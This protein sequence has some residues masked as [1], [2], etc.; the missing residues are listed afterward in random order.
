MRIKLS[1]YFANEPL[2]R[3]TPGRR[4]VWKGH[5]FVAN[6]PDAREC[7]IWAVLENPAEEEV[8]SVASGRI[9]LVTMEPQRK[10]DYQ[11]G[12]LAQ[13]DLVISCRRD[14]PHPNVRNDCQ[15]QPWHIG[16]HKGE[17]AIGPTS[18]CG[19]IDYDAFASMPMPQ[20]RIRRRD[21]GEARRP[22]GR[23]RPWGAACP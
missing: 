22:R 4:G 12:Y 1:Y 3:Q 16:M 7:D 18:L 9:V 19:T 5:T 11:P 8:A 14:L 17:E 21:A 23:L 15:G 2:L 10:R 6:D 13:F 20:K